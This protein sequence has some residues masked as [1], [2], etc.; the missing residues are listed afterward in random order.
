MADYQLQGQA[1][2]DKQ[3]WDSDQPPHEII[4]PL[5]H[6]LDDIQQYRRDANLHYLRM[7]SNRL[8]MGLSSRDYAIQDGGD[9][10]KLNVIKSVIDAATAQIGTHRVRPMFNTI[11]GNFSLQKRA[12]NLGKFVNG[13]FYALKQNT[14]SLQVF[15]DAGIFGTGFEYIYEHGGQVFGER[16]FPNEIL[17]DD[18][19][20]K[21]GT[22]R[23]MYRHKEVQRELVKAMYPQYADE[24]EEAALLRE[25][26]VTYSEATIDPISV[27]EAWHLPSGKE[28]KDG[29]RVLCISTKTLENDEWTRPRFPIIPFRW[30]DPVLGFYGIGLAEELASIQIEINYIIQKI[31]RLM[32]LSTT[33]IWVHKGSGVTTNSLNNQDAAVREYVGQIPTTTTPPPVAREYFEHLDRLYARGFEIAGISQ[34]TATSQKP[35]G[36]NSGEALRTYHD[37][38]SQRFQ[39]V[40]RRWEQFHLDV[41]EAIIDCARD[42]EGRGEGELE[43]LAQNDRD[44]ESIK[45]SEVSIE[46]DK[47]SMR[48]FPTSLLPDTPAGKLQTLRELAD[49]SPDMQQYIMQVLDVPDL[50]NVRSLINAPIDYVDKNLEAI[51]EHGKIIPPQPFMDLELARKRGTQAL[52]RAEIENY[53]EENI[54]LLRR[55]LVQVSEL[56]APPPPPPGQMAPGAGAVPGQG[57]VGSAPEMMQGPGG[58]GEMPLPAQ[59]PSPS[60]LN[61]MAPTQ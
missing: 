37:I 5:V 14:L 8:A 44:V 22:P 55:W 51:L 19:E 52:L 27:I 60:A 33:N 35:A 18:N 9:R 23:V 10:I 11:K 29:R 41:A 56:L 38:G 36:L 13:Q 24:I 40:G 42:I 12:K 49:I 48:V 43:V 30:A 54:E 39:H 15:Q 2:Q 6:Y 46:S 7:Y 26:G 17:V 4:Y 50:E 31:Q 28:A 57:P 61:A 32:T 1:P 20:S 53:P 25:E 45:F 58:L 3:W 21:Y 59:N 16:V 34:L 47:Y